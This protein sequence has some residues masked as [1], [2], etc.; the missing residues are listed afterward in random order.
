MSRI[1]PG[2]L[3]GIAATVVM[4]AAMRRLHRHLPA[5]QQYELPPREIVD[6]MGGSA[7]GSERGARDTALAAHFAFGGAAGGLFATLVPRPTLGTSCGYGLIVWVLSYLG[8]I[9]AARLLPPATHHP[10]ERNLLMLAVHLLWGAA[11]GASL[12]EIEHA[13]A[14]ILSSR[15]TPQKKETRGHRRASA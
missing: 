5:E 14:E 4:T 12:N 10:M 2:M 15:A 13:K 9:P 1:L 7:Q 3:A 6:S 8:W 11:L